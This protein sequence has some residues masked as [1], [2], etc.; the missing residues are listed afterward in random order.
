MDSASLQV[1]HGK[2]AAPT[3]G[4]AEFYSSLF[5]LKKW[6]ESPYYV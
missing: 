1:R 6:G 3:V 5:H 2:P 4:L